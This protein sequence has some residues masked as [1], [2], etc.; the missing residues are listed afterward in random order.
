MNISLST[1]PEAIKALASI[2]ALLTR[3]AS[4]IKA[5]IALS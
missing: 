2:R 3:A 4:V 1:K 5:S